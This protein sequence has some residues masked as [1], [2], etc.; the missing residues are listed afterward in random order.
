MN[1]LGAHDSDTVMALAV[2]A[3]VEGARRNEIKSTSLA[4]RKPSTNKLF[5]L[6]KG[7]LWESGR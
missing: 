5:Q 6:L 2:M 1:H 3:L 4:E 7:W